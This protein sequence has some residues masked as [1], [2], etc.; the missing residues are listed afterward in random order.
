MNREQSLH[1]ILIHGMGR[2]PL[3]MSL[4]AMRL[5][6]N[7]I[8]PHLFG[9]SVTFERWDK[10]TQRLE[11]FMRQRVGDHE[12]IVIG[13]SMGTVLTR[14]VLPRLTHKPLACFF[15]TPPTRVC[16][17]ARIITPRR[18]ARLLG[19]EFAQLL[20]DDQF[21]DSLPPTGVPTKIY[22]GT[23]GPRGRCSPF[24]DEPNDGVLMVKE[25]MLPGVPLQTVPIL[26]PFIMNSK[27]VTRDILK[28][29]KDHGQQHRPTFPI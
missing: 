25:T 3:A 21:M 1:A 14:T 22:A 28:L 27:I 9:Y 24:G 16:K 8:H 11:R 13:H 12:Y 20:A 23:A 4:L 10:C 17:M 29:T 26:H 7:H 18:T 19:G 6:A 2:T 5:R 15:L